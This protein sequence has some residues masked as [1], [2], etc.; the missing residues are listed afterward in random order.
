MVAIRTMRTQSKQPD[1]PSGSQVAAILA[2]ARTPAYRAMFML[3]YGAGLRV[4][5]MLCLTT[6]D[7]DAQRMVRT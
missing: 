1:V 6:E 7:L 5:E 4:S 2:H 3:L